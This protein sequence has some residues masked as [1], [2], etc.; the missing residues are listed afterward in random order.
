MIAVGADERATALRFASSI[1]SAR[2]DPIAVVRNYLPMIDWLKQAT[3][4]DDLS[5]R[6]GA[7]NQMWCNLP[8]EAADRGP[9]LDAPAAF[10]AGAAVFYMVVAT[11]DDAP[12]DAS[13]ITGGDS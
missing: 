11:D 8:D 4:D 3:D 6:L 9:L 13:A 10:V 12:D 2:H 1:T 5:L 7:L